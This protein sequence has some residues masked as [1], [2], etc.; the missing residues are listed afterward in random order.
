MS[1]ALVPSMLEC[2]WK[3]VCAHEACVDNLME[4]PPDGPLLL[5]VPIE[6]IAVIYKI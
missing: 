2:T 5:Y 1:V 3:N 4:F 6:R